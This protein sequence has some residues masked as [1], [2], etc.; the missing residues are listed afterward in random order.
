MKLNLGCGRKILP[1]FVNMDVVELAGVDVIHDI[2]DIPY[3]FKNEDFDYILASHVLEHLPH[4]VHGKDALLLVMK[5]LHRIL[6]PG[7][8]I[9]IRGPH[10]RIG[11][12]YF[13][14]PTHYRV[15]TQW[16]FDG[17]VG[18]THSSCVAFWSDIRFR[19]LVWTSE[20]YSDAP[21]NSDILK[22]LIRRAPWSRRLIGRPSELVI[23]LEK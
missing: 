17:L 8:A 7:G 18:E 12:Y 23:K 4:Q 22:G 5:E 10:P 11:I 2:L 6:K 1:G 16:T 13:N 19:R 20:T 15:I 3:P 9:E 21:F 14:N